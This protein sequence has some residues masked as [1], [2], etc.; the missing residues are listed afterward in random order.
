MCNGHWSMSREPWADRYPEGEMEGCDFER[1]N[2]V[3]LDRAR[4]QVFLRAC[5]CN[6]LRSDII[7]AGVSGKDI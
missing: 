7:Y 6:H 3:D 4:A 1:G 5:K 2:E